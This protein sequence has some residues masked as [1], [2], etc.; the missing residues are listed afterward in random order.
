MVWYAKTQR[1]FNS[2][3]RRNRQ[4]IAQAASLVARSELSKAEQLESRRM[5]VNYAG[6]AGADSFLIQVG[7]GN[8]TVTVNGVP[9]I[10]TDAAVASIIIDALGGNDT[11]TLLNNDT[12]NPTTINAGD[13]DD[14]IVIGAVGGGN[15][16]TAIDSTVTITDGTGTAD[17]LIFNDLADAAGSDTYTMTTDRTLVKPTSAATTWAG[18]NSVIVNGSPQPSTYDVN[19]DNGSGPV[20]LNGGGFVDTFN[21]GDAALDLQNNIDTSLVVDGNGGADVVTI[22]DTAETSAVT[23]TL[24][25]VGLTSNL[26]GTTIHVGFLSISSGTLNCAVG[27]IAHTYNILDLNGISS[28]TVNAGD[29]N[30]MLNYGDGVADINTIDVAITFNGQAGADRLNYNSQT[31]AIASSKTVTSTTIDSPQHGVLTHGTMES[32]VM[33]L[34]E[35]SEIVT[36]NSTPLTALTTV[37]AGDGNDT[38]NIGAGN[39]V[40]TVDENVTVNGGL[41]TDSLLID[42]SAN[43]V[44]RTWTLPGNSAT[45]SADAVTWNTTIGNQVESVSLLAGTGNDV[46]NVSNSNGNSALTVNGGNGLDTMTAGS[47]GSLLTWPGTVVFE[48]G[49]GVDNLLINDAA[50]NTTAQTYTFS[51]DITTLMTRTGFGGQVGFT[52]TTE[53]VTLDAGTG[54]ASALAQ[55]FNVNAVTGI[56]S[57]TLTI[58][59]GDGSDTTNVGGGDWGQN[60]DRDVSVNGGA[61]TDRVNISDSTNPDG[62]TYAL[63][64]GNMVSLDAGTAN[65]FWDVNVINIDLT[66]SPAAD[67]FTVAAMRAADNVTLRGGAGNDSLGTGTV[68]ADLDNIILGDLNFD[69]GA[70]VDSISFSDSEVADG[71]E[72]YDITGNDFKKVFIF[73]VHYNLIE[74]LNFTLDDD[75][76]VVTAGY[77]INGQSVTINAGTGNDTVQNNVANEW[78]TSWDNVSLNLAGGG[79]TD[80]LDLDDTASGAVTYGISNVAISSAAYA[81]VGPTNVAYNSFQTLLFLGSSTNNTI[82]ASG[83]DNNITSFTLNGGDGNDTI[84]VGG[85]TGSD[86]DDT[87]NFRTTMSITL[88]GGNGSDRLNIHDT[89]NEAGSDVYELTQSAFTVASG[90]ATPIVFNYNGNVDNIDV[91]GSDLAHTFNVEST[92]STNNITIGGGAAGDAF[93]IAPAT[94]DLNIIDAPVTIQGNGGTDSLTLSDT[95]NATNAVWSIGSASISRTGDNFASMGYDNTVESVN[96]DAGTLDDTFNVASLL[97][98]TALNL[99]GR[100]GNDTFNLASTSNMDAV[101]GEITVIGGAGT[102]SLNYNDSLNANVTTYGLGGIGSQR[103]TR[104]GAGTVAVSTQVESVLVTTGSANNIINVD[105]WSPF[106]VNGMTLNAGVGNDTIFV[107]NGD[108]DSN[109]LSPVNV[110]PGAGIDSLVF[111]D[112]T[113][114]DVGDTYTVTSGSITDGGSAAGVL[115]VYNG[116]NTEQLR[117]ELPG[118]A[119]VVNVESTSNLTSVTINGAAGNDTVNLG[120]GNVETLGSGPLLFD[121]GA[122][123]DQL[124]LLDTA[125]GTPNTWT[126]SAFSP[127]VGQIAIDADEIIRYTNISQVVQFSGVLAERYNIDALIAGT[128]VTINAGAGNDTLDYGGTANNVD[129]IDSLLRFGGDADSDLILFDDSASPAGRTYTVESIFLGSSVTPNLLYATTETISVNGGVGNDTL[130]I[131]GTIAGTTYDVAAGGGTDRFDVGDISND[132]DVEILASITLGGGAGDDTINYNDTG[133]TADPDSY[134]LDSSDLFSKSSLPVGVVVDG[135]LIETT[136]LNAN[137]GSNIITVNTAPSNLTINANGGDDDI[138][139]ADGGTSAAP[140]IVTSGAGNDTI[141]SDSDSDATEAFVR[142]AGTDEVARLRVGVGSTIQN[143]PGNSTLIVSST[144]SIGGALD[145]AGGF[146]IG[147]VGLG[148]PGFYNLVLTNGRNGGTWDGNFQSFSSSAATASGRSD[149]LGIRLATDPNLPGANIVTFGG[150][151]VNPGDTCIAFV[152]NGDTE[153][154]RDVDFDDLLRVAQNFNLPGPRAWTQGNFDYD[155]DVDFDDLL[156]TAQN[157]GLPFL[158]VAPSDK[159]IESARATL[160]QSATRRGISPAASRG[161]SRALQ[162]LEDRD[163]AM[164]ASASVIS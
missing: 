124:N 157:F 143:G 36:F 37:N 106:F 53:T 16:V 79:G 35:L 116:N 72:N 115:M 3:N 103:I 92:F 1:S 89:D 5:L 152:Q 164:F 159:Q 105:A 23:Y 50:A 42:D 63:N 97:V 4:R 52:S 81:A 122:D 91:L 65:I 78:A 22:D 76:S 26:I 24:D 111:N 17:I 90:S 102:D 140:V 13:G 54:G 21:I 10:R 56:S 32:L 163:D 113:D 148:I 39:F 30:D 20:T 158:T 87:T 130:F 77:F 135:N 75:S 126:Y 73:G 60:I 161:I 82:N 85:T 132:I 141:D 162:S 120:A 14:S 86:L 88:A 99:D 45:A 71:G 7:G 33:N 31:T 74:D 125:A 149:G 55:T 8:V 62:D 18:M 160:A 15:Y 58:N 144:I 134:T 6:T 117:I 112:S 131:E 68:P 40:T 147:R 94:D 19:T 11:V 139:V 25:S 154:D 129:L 64:A 95:L 109:V 83:L 84:N 9:D 69:G 98:T 12:T 150:Q 67:T 51:S 2:L 27:V 156:A 123:N 108:F 70:D 101:G 49:V 145:I 114:N 43:T 146:F 57:S 133:D 46:F 119:E 107:G 41:G 93:N 118:G 61:G 136:T 128:G 104:T 34:S 153:L 47:S 137:N 96:I 155:N 59:T 127:T 38:V 121:G 151:A 80:V 29:G 48:G 28:T 142:F 100:A 110:N 138:R 44:A 66:G